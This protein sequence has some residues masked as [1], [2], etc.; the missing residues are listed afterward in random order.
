MFSSLKHFCVHV[1]EFE[2]GANC[3]LSQLVIGTL[4]AAVQLSEKPD[5]GCSDESVEV[6]I[7]AGAR[8][9]MVKRRAKNCIV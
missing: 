7:V 2:N 5:I 9:A 1:A 6:A 3:T 4:Y 8:N